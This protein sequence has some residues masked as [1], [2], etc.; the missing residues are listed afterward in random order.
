MLSILL[1]DDE[2]TVA[3]F[4]RE[5]LEISGYRVAAYT[6]PQQACD[7]FLAAPDDYDL[8]VTDQT[9]PGLTGDQ[10]ASRL[11]ARK[12]DLP[13]ILVSGHSAVMDEDRAAALGIR[14]FLRKPLD[15]AALLNQ[16][17]AALPAGLG[18]A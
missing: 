5:L 1:V 14:A 12:P 13:I 7:A 4:M 18:P 2:P 8:V 6:E 16:I 17:K 15:H 3:G 11:I 10:L 9:M